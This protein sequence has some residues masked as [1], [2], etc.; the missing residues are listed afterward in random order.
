MSTE[1]PSWSVPFD[2]MTPAKIYSS[3]SSAH[4]N[5]LDLALTDLTA[6]SESV[7]RGTRVLEDGNFEVAT[8][9]EF[10]W[11]MGNEPPSEFFGLAWKNNRE[12]EAIYS[13]LLRLTDDGYDVRVQWRSFRTALATLW[14]HLPQ[15]YRAVRIAEENASADYS[16]S[17]SDVQEQRQELYDITELPQDYDPLTPFPQYQVPSDIDV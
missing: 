13:Q 6:H 14:R 1:K 15:Y 16:M 9:V 17:S 8:C 3:S 11:E 2:P 4:W 7:A 5:T 10:S 12:F